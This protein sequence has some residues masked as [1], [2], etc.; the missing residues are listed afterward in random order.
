MNVIAVV[1]IQLRLPE[2]LVFVC[3]FKGDVEKEPATKHQKTQK[4]H[5][6][7]TRLRQL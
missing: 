4:S 5:K 1:D 6:M 7:S 3:W 2:S